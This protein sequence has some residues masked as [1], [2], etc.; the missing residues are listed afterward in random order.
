MDVCNI[1]HMRDTLKPVYSDKRIMIV[2]E[3]PRSFVA[4]WKFCT[5]TLTTAEE[6]YIEAWFTATIGNHFPVTFEDFVVHKVNGATH[7]NMRLE[8][9]NGW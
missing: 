5:P 4:M 1:C 8:W 3:T 2:E 9:K 7:Y 6:S